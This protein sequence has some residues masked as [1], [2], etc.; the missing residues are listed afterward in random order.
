[1]LYCR[2]PED[3]IKPHSVLFEYRITMDDGALLADGWTKHAFLNS[4]GKVYRNDNKFCQWLLQ[5]VIMLGR[6]AD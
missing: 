4:E 6:S 2:I 3:Q 1:M 5:E